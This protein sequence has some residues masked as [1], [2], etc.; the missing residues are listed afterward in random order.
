V[1]KDRIIDG[2]SIAPGDVVIGLASSGPH[3]NGYSLIRK[4]VELRSAD[5]GSDLDGRTLGAA[6]LAPT[7]IYVKS[8]LGLLA[9]MPV[10][11]MAHITGGGLTGNIPR[12]L[13]RAVQVVLSQSAW[14]LPAIFAWLR[15]AGNIAAAEMHRTF[16][17]GLGMVIVVAAD[18]AERARARLASAGESAWI[19]GEVRARP[20]EAVQA[21]I[22]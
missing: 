6:L 4:I 14:P 5:L 17:C 8:L 2:C 3:S 9:E 18:D 16:N 20:P 1:E 10:K 22:A 7:R 13:P 21:L 11:G 12:I 15:D 19:V